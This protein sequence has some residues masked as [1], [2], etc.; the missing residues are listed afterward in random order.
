MRMVFALVLGLM[1]AG[2][3]ALAQADEKSQTADRVYD[4]VMEKVSSYGSLN[5]PKVMMVCIDWDAQTDSGIY[6]HNAFTTYT[7]SYSDG[8]IFVSELARDAK[9]RCKKWAESEKIDC[10]CQALD[11]NGKNVLDV[12]PRK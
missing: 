9:M 12:P 7:A 6:V 5:D 2:N 4:Y 10:T 3:N 1:A 11:K 8:P